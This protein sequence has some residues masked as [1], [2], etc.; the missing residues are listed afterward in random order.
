ME[1]ATTAKSSIPAIVP[2]LSNKNIE[3]SA[4]TR[5]LGSLINFLREEGAD[6]VFHD[7]NGVEIVTKFL[8]EETQSSN[9]NLKSF[10]LGMGVLLNCGSNEFIQSEMLK[11]QTPDVINKIL[12]CITSSA[13]TT[14]FQYFFI[15]F[16]NSNNF[17]KKN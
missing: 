8:E 5:V 10:W 3:R 9:P 17:L 2:V 6:T 7:C 12:E 1:G 13:F 15:K 4:R 16:S 11:C 14:F